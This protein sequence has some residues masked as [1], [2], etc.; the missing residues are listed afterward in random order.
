MLIVKWILVIL[1]TITAAAWFG[2]GLRLAGQA[3]TVAEG[4]APTLAKDAGRSVWLMNVFIVLTLLFSGAAFLV[5]GGFAGYGPAYH[6]SLLLI[7]VLTGLQLF[8]IRPAW[9]ALAGG[10]SDPESARKRVAIGTGIG[11]LT[12]LVILVLMFWKYLGPL[13]FGA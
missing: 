1:H 7:L 3:R 5:G 12:W 10:G 9:N 8:L 6:T 2:L 13:L 11:H 4:H